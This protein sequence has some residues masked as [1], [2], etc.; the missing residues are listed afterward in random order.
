MRK[1]SLVRETLV[2]LTEAEGRLAQG[3]D[4]TGQGLVKQATGTCASRCE[5]SCIF[6]WANTCGCTMDCPPKV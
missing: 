6:T 2:P 4:D 3:G 1:L 5:V